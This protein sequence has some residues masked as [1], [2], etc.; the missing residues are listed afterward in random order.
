MTETTVQNA[1]SRRR[2]LL[3]LPVL[4]IVAGCMQV[5][6]SPTAGP[7]PQNADPRVAAQVFNSACLESG[8]AFANTPA[9]LATLPFTQNARTGTFYHNSQNM[10]VKLQGSPANACSIVFGTTANPAQTLVAFGQ[11]LKAIAGDGNP[12]V[13]LDGS[14][15]PDGKN[16]LI[17]RF[18]R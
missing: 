1:H 3:V 15:G 11:R 9:A 7:G 17:A 13:L 8:P 18:S 10:S 14:R 6:Q 4:A 5:P 12:N 16:Y 2:P